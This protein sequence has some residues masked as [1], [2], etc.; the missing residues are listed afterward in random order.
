MLTKGETQ[1]VSTAARSNALTWATACPAL[2]LFAPLLLPLL[3]GRV[4]AHTDLGVFYLPMRKMYSEALA[5][6]QPF[7]WSSLL[8]NGYYVH[9][10]GQVGALHPWHLLLYGTLPLGIA[11]NLELISAYVFAFG[12]MWLF[13]RRLSVSLPTRSVGATA[14]AFS[15]FYLLRLGHLNAIQVAAHIPLLLLAVDL[16]LTGSARER[17]SATAGM[18]LLTGSQVLLGYPHYVWI[19]ALIWFTYVVVLAGERTVWRHL[20]LPPL[21]GLAGLMVGG[22]Q[23]LPTLELLGNSER[24]VAGP[25]FQMSFSLHPLNLLQLW[26]PYVLPSRVFAEPEELYL[27]EFGVYNG[28]L[29]TVAI[30]WTLLRWRQ[31]PFARTARFAGVLCILG[32]LLALGSYGFLYEFVSTLPFLRGFRAPARHIL[33]L[34]VGL[35]LLLA[36]M[37]EDLQ[38]RVRA[39]PSKAAL[40]WL[41]GPQ[42]VGLIITTTGLLWWY[43]LPAIS[44]PEGYPAYAL[45]GLGFVV[46][47]TMLVRDASRGVRAALLVIPSFLAIDLG[48]WGYSY[49]FGSPPM[50]IQ[51]IADLAAPPDGIQVTN[52]HDATGAP[53]VNYFLFRDARIFKAHVG[54]QPERRLSPADDDT[55][56]LAGVEWVRA[57]SKWRQVHKPMPRARIILRSRFSHDS[58]ADMSSIDIEETA[59]VDQHISLPTESAQARLS[60]LRDEPGRM[61]FKIDATATAILAITESYHRDWQVSGCVPGCQ[62]LRIYGDYLGVLLTSGQ[63]RLDLTFTPRSLRY[64]W[65]LTGAGLGLTL[66][67]STAAGSARFNDRWT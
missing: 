28:A 12:G 3:A 15:G 43:W 19:S 4:F 24:A 45:T 36:I 10:E 48:V 42:A 56:R 49:A 7:L 38:S 64:G 35:C 26:S 44:R 5:Q 30:A 53:T 1:S 18:A 60:I 39:R 20:W 65:W 34:H 57:G 46:L 27:H 16:I 22:I 62:T 9:G 40:R 21:A 8:S 55:L 54:L 11:F 58:A 14:F 32:I 37:Y 23:L 2:V 41:G 50:T 59:L 31:L 13:L 17:R 52:L 47:A 51:Q 6:G 29:C 61:Q 67:L 66:L 33:L 63:Y 25:E